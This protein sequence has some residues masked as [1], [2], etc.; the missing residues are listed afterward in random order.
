MLQLPLSEKRLGRRGNVPPYA[1]RRR[2]AGNQA[3]VGR[4]GGV[5]LMAHMSQLPW[6]ATNSAYA[7]H[8]G[9]KKPSVLVD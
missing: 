7:H 1:R 2:C 9:K 3:S 6:C 8:P 4:C 5:D